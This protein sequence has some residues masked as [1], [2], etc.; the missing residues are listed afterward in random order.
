M[1][2]LVVAID[3]RRDVG[4][5]QVVHQ[6]TP[7][8]RQLHRGLATHRMAHHIHPPPMGCNHFGQIFCHLGIGM[9][10]HS[11][12]FAMVAHIDRHHIAL[13]RHAPRDDTPVARR[14]EQPMHNEQG[15]QRFGRL[16]GVQNCVQHAP[17]HIAARRVV[18]EQLNRVSS[19]HKL[20]AINKGGSIWARYRFNKWRNGSLRC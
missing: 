3:H 15:R 14:S 7:C 8:Q 11:G 19:P 17:S 6:I 12:A 1:P 20:Q 9:A 13:I 2:A 4:H 18:P 5:D 16:S 10:W